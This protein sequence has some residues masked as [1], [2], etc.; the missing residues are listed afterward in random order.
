M[1]HKAVN[2]PFSYYMLFQVPRRTPEGVRGILCVG[3][4][5]TGLGRPKGLQD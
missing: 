3:L 4:S 1:S 2:I 5:A